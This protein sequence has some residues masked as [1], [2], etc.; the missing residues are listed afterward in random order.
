MI[1]SLPMYWR[2]ETAALWQTF[3]SHVQTAHDGPLPDLTPPEALPQNW[4][5]H[6]LDPALA[7][8]MT[9]SLPFRTA[10]RGKVTYVGTLGYGLKAP[11]GMYYSCVITRPDTMLMTNDQPTRPPARRA[12][13]AYNS[14]DSQSGW[15][16]TQAA[17]P[18][19]APLQI[20]KVVETGGHAQSLAAVAAGRADV[21]YLDAVT[22]RLLKRYDPDAQRVIP[23]GSTDPTPGLPLICAKGRDPEPLRAAV[24]AATTAFA[25]QDPMAMGGP[26]SFHVLDEAA[27]LSQPIPTPP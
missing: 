10:L 3:W 26:L 27:Y 18:F 24:H 19:G 15:A 12:T 8:S 9:C 23:K 17:A 2:A 4:A 13:L 5:E 20:G 14:A 21:A 1:A 11:P 7:L 25:P 16:V 22:W 6:W